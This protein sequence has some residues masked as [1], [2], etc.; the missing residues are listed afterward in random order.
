MKKRLSTAVN[1]SVQG[2]IHYVWEGL[3]LLFW[4][5]Q[6]NC[7]NFFCLN[8]VT[9]TVYGYKKELSSG[10]TLSYLEVELPGVPL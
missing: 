7:V 2:D 1:K 10:T 9:T 6:G 5:Q 4:Q 3:A 8:V